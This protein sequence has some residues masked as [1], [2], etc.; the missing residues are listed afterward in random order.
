M[1]G[2]KMSRAVAIG[3]VGLSFSTVVQAAL[4][5]EYYRRAREQAAYHVQVGITK[6]T[7]PR[8]GPGGCVV[9]GQVLRIFKNE[10]ETLT[11]DMRIGF[12]VACYRQGESVPIGGTQWLNTDELEKAD[13]MEVYLDDVD[14]S[15][16]PAMWNYRLIPELSET[17]Q[18]P[19][20]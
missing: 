14:G 17:P 2:A 15:L 18:L 11:P 19:V 10:G 6:V 3:L 4:A 13:Y 7:A 20:D 16:E 5:P 1:G 9:E 8:P 12:P